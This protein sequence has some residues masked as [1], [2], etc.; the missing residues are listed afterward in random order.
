MTVT[1]PSVTE[2]VTWSSP[3]QAPKAVPTTSGDAVARMRN[4]CDAALAHLEPGFAA[5][6]IDPP[7]LPPEVDGNRRRSVLSMAIEPVRQAEFRDYG[8]GVDDPHANA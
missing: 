8:V 5:Q 2:I 3:L 1:T 7:F 4:G 6:Q